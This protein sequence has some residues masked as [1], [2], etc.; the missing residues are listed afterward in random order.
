MKTKKRMHTVHKET[1]QATTR[2]RVKVR[3]S[4]DGTNSQ[5]DA[6][7]DSEKEDFARSEPSE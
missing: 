6:I 5:N 3:G 7:E 1:L 4:I 2:T